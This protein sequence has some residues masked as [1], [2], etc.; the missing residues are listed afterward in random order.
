MNLGTKLL[1]FAL[2]IICLFISSFGYGL[3][4]YDLE[5]PHICYFINPDFEN[6]NFN[7]RNKFDTTIVKENIEFIDYTI[8]HRD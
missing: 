1:I 3:N 6:N 2:T 5:A 7:L 4:Y 8:R